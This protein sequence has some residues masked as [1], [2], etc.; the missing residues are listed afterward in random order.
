MTTPEDQPASVEPVVETFERPPFATTSTKD[1]LDFGLF[2]VVHRQRLVEIIT[3][4]FDACAGKPLRDR[5]LA[6]ILSQSLEGAVVQLCSCTKWTLELL[7][8]IKAGRL[9]D[10]A[11]PRPGPGKPTPQQEEALREG[12]EC[13][14]FLFPEAVARQAGVPNA[15][16]IEKVE[17][18][19]RKVL[20]PLVV[21]RDK[22]VAH[23]D[24]LPQQRATW[25]DL[26]D[27]FRVLTPLYANL[28]RLH[29]GGPYQ[30]PTLS[31]HSRESTSYLLAAG[32]QRE[33]RRKRPSPTTRPTIRC[34]W[35]YW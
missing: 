32:I 11:R 19:V 7:G 34:S 27:A 20:E 24:P 23:W 10:F 13:F 18:V 25:G 31:P 12:R 4:A 8:Q 28:W 33:V 17:E 16:D 15:S 21:H 1:L 2:Q 5:Y 30:V 26:V 29:T 9:R 22:I 14:R 3:R 6:D 35:L